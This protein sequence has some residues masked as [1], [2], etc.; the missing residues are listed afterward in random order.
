MHLHDTSPHRSLLCL[1]LLAA[2]LASALPAA[3]MFASAP[4]PPPTDQLFEHH[5]LTL[6]PAEGSTVLTGRFLGRETAELAV[7]HVDEQGA[8]QL[9]LYTL[10]D[11]RWERS[12][13]ARLRP[14]LAF[15]DV[16]RSG[17]RD[18]LLTWGSGR[19]H[20]FDPGTGF[21]HPLVDIPTPF[22]RLAAGS[23]GYA[24]HEPMDPSH[25]SQIPW[26]DVTRDLDGDGLDD[27]AVPD[28]DGFW[29]ARQTPAG[30]FATATRLGPPEPF[31]DAQ[32]M[33]LFDE[34]RSY[35]EA[36]IDAVTVPWYLSRLHQ[37]DHDGDG[38]LDLAFWDE[39]HF[40]V[41]HQDAHG[42][43]EPVAE[44]FEP[45]VAFG[46]D[47]PYTLLFGW[48]RKS[49]MAWL[50]GL[51]GETR[52]TTLHAVTDVDGDGLADLVT[53]TL[54]GRNMLGMRSTF[55]VHP[56]SLSDGG[57]EFAPEAS[58]TLRAPRMGPAFLALAGYSAQRLEDLDGDGQ[59]DMAFGHVDMGLGGMF[60]AM[61]GNAIK[62]RVAFYRN[63]DGRFPDEATTKR[64]VS[65]DY[66]GDRESGDVFFPTVRLGDVD[67]DGRPDLVV[68]RDWTDLQVFHGVAGA[69]LFTTVPQRVEVPVPHDERNTWLTD[70][71]GD[72]KQDIVLNHP[73]HR[74]AP[75]R[76]ELLV[77][78]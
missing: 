73:P 40:A 64:Q 55:E 71:N 70:V 57:L 10:G 4:L 26:V 53:H 63:D 28:L 38:R 72:G 61:A 27:L 17:S 76:L 67:G 45:G 60:H 58:A 7:L 68:G 25:G 18:L 39:D 16:A 69:G 30:S 59:L 1:P 35:R 24:R 65:P 50:F 14:D 47:G 52:R 54:E 56:G 66:D 23:E 3:C 62:L 51:G 8:R 12:L 33:S 22:R 41:H 11:E 20:V 21:E 78:R 36:G 75:H 46:F 42:N 9:T 44:R 5:A 49:P 37:L 13:D 15:V 19:V 77:A 43:F 31:L 32:P 34:T 29:I 48:E 2:L 74:G 6:G